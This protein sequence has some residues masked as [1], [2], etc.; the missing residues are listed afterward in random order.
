MAWDAFW[1]R[2]MTSVPTAG[3]LEVDHAA[4][5]LVLLHEHLF[6]TDALLLL[7]WPHLF[8]KGRVVA[9]VVRQ[10][11][12]AYQAGIRTVVDCTTPE[13]SRNVGLMETV[14]HQTRVNLLVATGF[15]SHPLR[16]VVR[17]DPRIATELYVRDIVEGIGGSRIRAALLS[18]STMTAT[19]A[20]EV[21]L[22]A[23]AWAHRETG[24]PILAQAA[25]PHGL[26]QQ[27][28]FRKEGVDLS[29]VLVG[30]P[31]GSD[32]VEYLASLIEAGG[33]V[34]IDGFSR[35]GAEAA[36]TNR[37][38][39]VADL[40]ARGLGSRIVISTH[41][42]AHVVRTSAAVPDRADEELDLS[43][44]PARVFPALRALGVPYHDLHAMTVS[45]PQSLFERKA[46]K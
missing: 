3:G 45:T 17:D 31:D 10:L 1:S 14:A 24:V 7:N 6:L 13:L 38:R 36:L 30:H 15:H 12:S 21:Q 9:A 19:P 18:A 2:T 23:V 29:Q 26:E 40:C 42:G 39:T 27:R 22:R 37:C 33:L 46:V 35:A 43:G 28:I 34:A 5:G 44:L 8:D 20:N 32:D 4:L 16:Y 25:A 11:E 41:P